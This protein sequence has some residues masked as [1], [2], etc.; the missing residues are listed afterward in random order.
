ML[1]SAG[2]FIV[3]N[4]D[5]N[6]LLFSVKFAVYAAYTFLKWGGVLSLVYPSSAL[7][8]WSCCWW[9]RCYWEWR[10]LLV[11]FLEVDFFW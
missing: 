10:L 4:R 1:G 2:A 5:C 11:F 8:L 3:C 7:E 6:M 9:P